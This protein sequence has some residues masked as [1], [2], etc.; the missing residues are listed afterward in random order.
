MVHD[1][2]ISHKARS[3]T[4]IVDQV[5]CRFKIWCIDG[6]FH[7]L[8]L[9]SDWKLNCKHAI[10]SE[11][12]IKYP[13]WLHC[14]TYWFSV[15]VVLSI[16]QTFQFKI[17]YTKLCNSVLPKNREGQPTNHRLSGISLLYH[18]LHCMIRFCRSVYSVILQG[19][20]NLHGA[21]QNAEQ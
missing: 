6:H 5:K 12:Y 10:D 17:A 1:R 14:T 4:R 7:I 9:Q 20:L 16:I 19:V 18:F 3:F 11:L 8:R 21:V 2:L 13:L 15:L